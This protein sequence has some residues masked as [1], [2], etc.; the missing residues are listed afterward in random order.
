MLGQLKR[1]SYSFRF[2]VDFLFLLFSVGSPFIPA[3]GI[4]F[5]LII[6]II[7][8]KTLFFYLLKYK[9]SFYILL[10]YSF[11]FILHS[12][13]RAQTTADLL[14]SLQIVIK[15]FIFLFNGFL[16]GSIVKRRPS[17]LFYWVL[18]Q[19]IL[20]LLSASNNFVYN[21]LLSFISPAAHHTFSS[22][23]G[24]RSLG[25]GLYHVDGSLQYAFMALISFIAINRLNSIYSIALVLLSLLSLLVARSAV[26]ILSLFLFLISPCKLLF[27]ICVYITVGYYSSEDW[28]PIYSSTEL[29]RNFLDS[30]EFYTVSTN[31][32][33]NMFIFP[34]NI[35]GWLFGQGR[36]FESDGLFY[37]QTDLGWIR[38]LLFGG[39]PYIFLFILL[40][41]TLII[42]MPPNKNKLL[43]FVLSSFI[44]LNFKGIFVVSFF[45]GFFI[46]YTHDIKKCNQF[47]PKLQN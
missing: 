17:L 16:A 30:G 42:K 39:I 22:I 26:V 32:N 31:E 28:G 33:L 14:F 11:L 10:S 44:I 1:I 37:M 38:L 29:I 45:L 9:K 43:I 18:F 21:L 13:W 25:F 15:Y 47:F 5:F 19:A 46:S 24:L 2:I 20:I 36:F 12:I 6:F 23:Y 40:N 35:S 3:T 7:K 4:P 41:L 8:F 34:D 27:A